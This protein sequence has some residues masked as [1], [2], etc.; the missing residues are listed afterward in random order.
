MQLKSEGKQM[1]PAGSYRAFLCDEEHAYP[2]LLR[3]NEDGKAS[4]MLPAHTPLGSSLCV[5]YW[6]NLSIDF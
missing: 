3:L 5:Q 2:V 4:C 6:A 1:L